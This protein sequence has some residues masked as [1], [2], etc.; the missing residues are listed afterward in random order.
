MLGESVYSTRLVEIL[1]AGCLWAYRFDGLCCPIDTGLRQYDSGGGV[2]SVYIFTYPASIGQQTKEPMLLQ[3]MRLNRLI[4]DRIRG[5]DTFECDN[6][7]FTEK[8][9]QVSPHSVSVPTRPVIVFRSPFLSEKRYRHPAH[10]ILN[11]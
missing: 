7:C 8:Y 3:L 9:L 10:Q 1:I 6:A 5:A 2:C 11:A 4:S